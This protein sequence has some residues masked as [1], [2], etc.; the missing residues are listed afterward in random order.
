VDKQTGCRVIAFSQDSNHN[1][2]D[3]KISG[4]FIGN[5]PEEYEIDNVRASKAEMSYFGLCKIEYLLLRQDG[6]MFFKDQHVDIFS[7]YAYPIAYLIFIM[8]L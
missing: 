8:I 4:S 7:R 6:N 3:S 5:N 2:S 1:K